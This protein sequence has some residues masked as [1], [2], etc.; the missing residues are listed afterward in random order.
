MK[1][2]KQIEGLKGQTADILE[3]AYNKGYAQGYRDYD[4]NEAFFEGKIREIRR[5]I[6]NTGIQLKYME[7]EDL[8]PG[9]AVHSQDVYELTIVQLRNNIV[10]LYEMLGGELENG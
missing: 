10:M 9:E 1:N 2:Y 8:F 6:E 7:R 5:K 3:T 4:I